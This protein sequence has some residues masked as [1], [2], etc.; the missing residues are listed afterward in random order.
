M[1]GE[2]KLDA[3]RNRLLW[4]IQR[5][6]V[7]ST[8]E[9]RIG[10]LRFPFTRIADPDRVLDEVAEEADRR[11]RQTGKRQQDEQLHLPYWAELWDSAMGMAQVMVR[12]EDHELEGAISEAKPDTMSACLPVSLPS[13]SVLDLGCG[14]GLSG[15]VAAALRARVMFADIEPPALLFARLN[16]LPW[17]RRVRARRVNWKTNQ[18]GEKFDVILG[19]DIV[20]ER[21]Q[22]EFLEP[23]WRGHL[24]EGGVVMLG[25]PGRQTGDLFM[26]WVRKKGWG[27]NVTEEKVA[28]RERPIRILFLTQR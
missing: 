1:P 23:F 17:R 18:L 19:A 8:S 22:W 2:I 5:R 14:M 26:E 6:Y 16:S 27:L 24:K 21:G 12:G 15:T 4:R 9:V 11:E 7:T 28:T 20:Y 13:A 3:I 10:P 25:E